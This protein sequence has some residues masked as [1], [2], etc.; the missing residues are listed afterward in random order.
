MKVKSGF[1][2]LKKHNESKKIH[3]HGKPDVGKNRRGVCI[4]VDTIF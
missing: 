2:F 3:I 4:P 1:K